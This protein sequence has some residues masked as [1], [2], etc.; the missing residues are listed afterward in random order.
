MKVQEPLSQVEEMM[1]SPV[2]TLYS[3]FANLIK[4]HVMMQAW[5]VK[6]VSRNTLAIA[7]VL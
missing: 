5:L 6:E 2:Y 1:I 3:E 4:V 7:A